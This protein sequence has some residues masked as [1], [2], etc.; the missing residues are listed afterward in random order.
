[1]VQEQQQPTYADLI[2]ARIEAR[3]QARRQRGAGEAPLLMQGS[4]MLSR[5]TRDI[6]RQA[7]QEI[8]SPPESQRTPA[9]TIPLSVPQQVTPPPPSTL[10]KVG[11]AVGGALAPAL[12]FPLTNIGGQDVTLGKGLANIGKL[13][14][15]GARHIGGGLMGA[16]LPIPEERNPGKQFEAGRLPSPY[17]GLG[18]FVFDPIN[19]LPGGAAKKV[20]NLSPAATKA[21]PAVQA[22]I[23]KNVTAQTPLGIKKAAVKATE[24]V[25]QDKPGVISLMIDRI[26]VIRQLRRITRPGLDMPDSVLV[27][28]NAEYGVGAELR[29]TNFA[30]AHGVVQSL[31]QTFGRGSSKGEAVVSARFLGGVDDQWPAVGTLYDIAQRPHLYDLTPEQKLLLKDLDDSYAMYLDDH[32]ASFGDDIGRFPSAPGGWF[33]PNVDKSDFALEIFGG[34]IV[35]AARSGGAA[36]RVF[37]TGFDRWKLNKLFVPVTDINLLIMRMD[38]TRVSHAMRNTFREISG[39]KTKVQLMDELHPVLVATKEALRKEMIS[40]RGKIE[41]AI[42]LQSTLKA[43][44]RSE[45][46]AAKAAARRAEPMLARIQALGTDYGP[47]LSYLSGQVRE[48]HIAATK[49]TKEGMDLYNKSVGQGVKRQTLTTRLHAIAPVLDSLRRS[50]EAADI[51]PY[52]LV[53]DGLF[54]YYPFAEAQAIQNVRKVSR[55]A[56]VDFMQNVTATKLS[57]DLSPLLGIQTPIGFLADPVGVSR[58]WMKQNPLAQLS[59]EKLAELITQDPRSWKDYAFYV[60]RPVTLSATPQEFAGGFLSKLPVV[61][62]KYDELNKRL[63]LLVE[64]QSK[65]LWDSYVADNIARGMTDTAAKVAA[66]DTVQKVYPH[67]SPARYGQSPARAATLRAMTTSISFAVKPAEMMLDAMRGFVKL[68]ALQRPTAR[69]LAGVRVMTTMAS[70]TLFASVTSSLLSARVRGIDEEEALAQALNPGSRHFMALT[71]G[72]RTIPL[73]GP[74]RSALKAIWPQEVE[75]SPVPIPFWGV[76]QWAKSRGQPL[77]VAGIDLLRNKDF[78]GNEIYGSVFPWNIAAAVAYV[79]E[80]VLPISVGSVATGVRTGQGTG[81]IAEQLGGQVLGVN[82][83]ENTAYQERDLA[84]QRWARAKGLTAKSWADVTPSEQL[85]FGAENPGVAADLRRYQERQA[86]NGVDWAVRKKA[87][88]DLEDTRM[89]RETALEEEFKRREI[90]GDTFRDAYGEIQLGIVSSK[91]Q[92][93]ADYQLYTQTNERPTDPN[94]AALFDYYRLFDEAKTPSG[95]MNWELFDERITALE[96]AWTSSQQSYVDQNTGLA[97]HPPLIKEWRDGKRRFTAYWSAGDMVLQAIGQGDMKSIYQQYKSAPGPVQREI[98][99]TNRALFAQVQRAED[100]ARSLARRQSP[101]LDAFL[102]RFGYVTVPGNAANRS[103][104]TLINNLNVP[105]QEV[106]AT[107]G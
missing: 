40:L 14:V 29:T 105:L 86:A 21:A 15:S 37:G 47:E 36:A 65:G 55:N 82:I 52:Q 7:A 88:L 92:V 74:F 101:E 84:V 100:S 6:I 77:G 49:L 13:G 63:Y 54:R 34:D 16:D 2:L 89:K 85:A 68:G 32:N 66:A 41:T 106:M 20:A 58:V 35:A 42:R 97:G 46:T 9:N 48:L 80:S 3:R 69:E 91:K 60:Q 90:S 28:K 31:E 61:G 102:M 5:P 23:A 27:A 67:L 71:L 22:A 59:V 70:T 33:L 76:A 62:K 10:E 56:A 72:D 73:G 18:E 79:G 107:T 44:A 93:D 103:R 87:L 1:M 99:R 39:G 81:R 75:G 64:I 43:G 95:R 53:E 25:A 51:R 17:Q 45:L 96:L 19:A 24:M 38:E 30:I 98:N 94:K 26:P 8:T 78:Y 83:Q 104:A 4:P 57:A 11:A 50:Y 12:N